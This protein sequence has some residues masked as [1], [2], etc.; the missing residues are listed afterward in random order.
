MGAIHGANG[1]QIM[2]M[3]REKIK[4][5]KNFIKKGIDRPT[6]RIVFMFRSKS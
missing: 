1:P 5:E 2:N 6:V 4:Q 3:I